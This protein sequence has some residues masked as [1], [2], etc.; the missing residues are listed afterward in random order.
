MPPL[1][2]GGSGIVYGVTSDDGKELAAKVLDGTKATKTRLK[3]F[4]NEYLFGYRNEH[5]NVLTILDQGVLKTEKAS[6]PFYIMPRYPSSLRG[7]MKAGLDDRKRLDVFARILLGVEAAHLQG[8][9]HRDIKPENILVNGAETIVVADFGIA[10]F[11]E[12]DL[13]TAVETRDE[14]LA[15]FLYSAPE[16]RVRGRVVDARADIYALGLMLNE[17]FTGEVPAGTSY[18]TVRAT[19]PTLA[20]IDDVVAQ[21]ICQA[22]DE[23]PESIAAVKARMGRFEQQFMTQQK[24]DELKRTIVPVGN[25]TDPLAL[26]PVTVTNADWNDGVL[27]LTLSRPVHQKW[28][29]ALQNIGSYRSVDRAD[30]PAFRFQGNIARVGVS[31]N[32]AQMAL[33]CFKEW[34]PRA[35]AVLRQMLEREIQQAEEEH[36]NR[37][38][39][40]RHQLDERQRVVG[41]L[42]I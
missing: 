14:R 12:D 15:N 30:P 38:S 42:R 35:T 8:V 16:Q 26:E 34:L 21:M 32:Q 41:G 3:R 9:V 2:E 31:G 13:Y 28:I 20:W 40:A 36:R 24:L 37:I 10:R 29:Q 22:P 6:S 19:T 4:K 17:L 25:I 5:A 1:G 18:R 23:R 33:D 7:L 27:I 39:V 11:E